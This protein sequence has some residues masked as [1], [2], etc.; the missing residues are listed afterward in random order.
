MEKEQRIFNALELRTSESSNEKIIEGYAVVF[1]KVTTIGNSFYEIIDY[2]ALN[3][4]DLSDVALF[5]NHNS[6]AIPLART[7]SGTMTVAID[8]IGLAIRARLDTEN[9]Q[10]ARDLF[11]A[12]QRG[13]LSG[14]SFCFYVA[15]DEWENINTDMPLRIIKKIARILEV[16]V[17]SYPAYPQTSISARGKTTLK[18]ARQKAA[19]NEKELARL[20]AAVQETGK[21]LERELKEM[22]KESRGNYEA[23]GKE[24]RELKSKVQSPYTITGEMR[25]VTVRPPTGE[26]SKIAVPTHYAGTIHPAFPVVSTL[27]DSVQ[28]YSLHGGQEFKVPYVVGFDDAYY[29]DE[30]ANAAILDAQ[31]SYAELNMAKVSAFAELSEELE[32]LPNASYANIIFDIVRTSIRKAITK[33]ILFGKGISDDGNH[34]RIVGIFSNCKYATAIAPTTD[35][36]IAQ[37]TDTLLDEIQLAYGGDTDLDS[38]ATLII[39]KQD[40]IALSMVRSSVKSR[41]NEIVYTSSNT[42]RI[43]GVPFIIDSNL[44]AVTDSKTKGGEYVMCFGNPKNYSLV[45]FSPLTIEKSTHYKFP[46]GFIAFRGSAYVAGNVTRRNGFIRIKKA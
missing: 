22:E 27:I 38:A 26:A 2:D 19:T 14:M 5:V 21:K 6:E 36:S 42:G 34:N 40:L 11:S 7:T 10:A 30:E 8:N 15:D 18:A 35:I 23:A 16:S 46:Q 28:V 20:K 17:V 9:S 44:P 4:C 29:S 1:G 33:E 37:I 24:L 45:E 25:T 12:I 32:K 3:D 31:F 43:N 13:D 39:S 41:L